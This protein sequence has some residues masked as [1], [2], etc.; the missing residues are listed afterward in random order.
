MKVT[1]VSSATIMFREG[2][3]IVEFNDGA[4]IGIEE[5]N[6][7]MKAAN[8]LTGGTP[9]PVI[10]IDY[11]PSTILSPEAR[12]IF[13]NEIQT[14]KRLSEAFVISSLPKRLMADFYTRYHK[15]QNPTKIFTNFN[16]AWRWSVA[17]KK[18]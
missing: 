6:D 2:I 16:Q 13:A 12:E 11:S 14:G 3:L 17:N 7:Q 9:C 1:R 15:Q 10:I 5:A 4:S 18:S 8:K